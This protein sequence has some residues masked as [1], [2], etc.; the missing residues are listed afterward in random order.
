MTILRKLRK[1][2]KSSMRSVRHIDLLAEC[3]C[4]GTHSLL[5][6]QEYKIWFVARHRLM[7]AGYR[8]LSH[9][10]SQEKERTVLIRLTHNACTRLAQSHLS[11]VSGQRRVRPRIS[12]LLHFYPDHPILTL[13]QSPKQTLHDPSSSPWHTYFLPS[14][15]LPPNRHSSDPQTRRAWL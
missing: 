9:T 13:S 7:L 11:M 4:A 2:T 6:L 5:I 14:A 3:P 1:R 8:S 15:R 10:R 12:S